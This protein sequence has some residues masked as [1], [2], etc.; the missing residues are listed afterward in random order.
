MASDR[1]TRAKSGGIAKLDAVPLL[2]GLLVLNPF[3][4]LFP[5]LGLEGG[6]ARGVARGVGRAEPAWL[7][8]REGS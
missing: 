3:Q 2:G 4:D 1:A 5:F 7:L 6:V 8:N